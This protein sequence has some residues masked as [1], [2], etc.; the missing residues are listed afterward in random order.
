[1]TFTRTGRPHRR[2]AIPVLLAAA[3]LLGA[4]CTDFDV[5]TAFPPDAASAQ[6]QET[7]NLYDI[8]FFIGIAIFLFV[9]GLILFAVLRYR[10]RR[11]DDELP[12][13]IHGNNKLEI[14][15]TAVPIAI[16]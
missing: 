8:V 2:A 16:V 9:E 4:G 14:L 12:P 5:R 7:R 3:A 11:G 15:W 6:G 13:Q 10:R 1:M